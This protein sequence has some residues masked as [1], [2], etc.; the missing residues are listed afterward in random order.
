MSEI[1]WIVLMICVT[2]VLVAVVLVAVFALPQ[3]RSVFKVFRV[4][5]NK[6]GIDATIETK[7]NA[8]TMVD[9]NMML[10]KKNKLNVEGRNVSARDNITLGSENEINVNPTR[11]KTTK[12]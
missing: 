6:Q 5:A 4:K 3:L 9:G 12:K 2:V 11:K 10:G 1:F 8:A 7:P